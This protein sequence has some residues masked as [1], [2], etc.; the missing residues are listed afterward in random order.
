MGQTG[1]G[2]GAAWG[3]DPGTLTPNPPATMLK[4]LIPAAAL[5]LAAAPLLA[6]A[7]AADETRLLRFPATNGKQIV[8][9]YA[10]QLYTV[11]VDGG[12]ARRLT[13]TPGYAVFPR[14][15]ADGSQ[16]AFTA[17]YD[18][19]TEVY[20]MP[21]EGGTPKRL[22]YTATL[23]RDDVSDRMGPNNLVMAWKNTSNEI[24]FR[25]RMTSF[26]SFV[27]QLYTVGTDG[28]VPKQVPVP[29]GGFLSYSPDDTKMA[30]NQVFREFRTW[31]DYRGGMADDIWIFDFKT[32]AVE[33]ITNDAAQD[34][35]PM[36]GPDNR[37]YFL[38]DREAGGAKRMNLYSYDLATKATAQLTHF[39]DFDIK[40]PSLGGGVV[41]F[42]E[43]GYIWAYDIRKGSAQRVPIAVRDDFVTSRPERINVAKYVESVNIAPDGKRVVV[44]ARG[45]T[46]TVPAK[47]GATRNLTRKEGIHE[48][49][50]VWSPDGRWIAYISD[51][52]GENEIYVRPQD[53]SAE[54]TQLTTGAD[55]YYYFPVWSPDG[56]KLL[57]GD[58]LQRLRFVTVETKAVTLVDTATAFEVTQY[59]WS[60][61]SQWITWA[62]PEDESLSKVWLYSLAGSRKFEVTDG[63]YEAS[64]PAFS[65]DG[66]FLLLASGR[67]FNRTLSEVEFDH[68]YKDLER[69]YL[70]ALSKD[71]DSPF[72]PKSDE[73]EIAPA[74]KPDDKPAD[75]KA[76]DGKDAK[77]DAAP[78]PVVVKVDEDGIKD[79]LVGLPIKA[80][81]YESIHSVGDKVYYLRADEGGDGEEDAGPPPKTLAMYD[82]KERKETELG[83][84]FGYDLSAD[85]KKMLLSVGKDF[86]VIDTPTSKIEVKDR[87]SFAG[88]SMRVDRHAEW[89]QIYDECWRQMRDFFF[90]PTMNGVDW[91]AMRAKYA[92]LVPY[93]QTRYDLTYLLG[94]L[95]GE[96]HSG[97]TYVGGGDRPMAPR[98]TMGLLGAKLSRDPASRDYRIDKI[99]RG[100]NWQSAGRSPLTEIGVNV[101]EG[102]YI[103]AVDGKSVKDM[104][105]IYS[106][107]VGKADVQ[108]VL[109][110][111]SK[112]TD[113]GA[114]NV[115]VL[116]I[117][118]EAPLYYMTWVR[119]NIDYV[120]EKTG[121]KVGYI[122]IPDMGP[123]GLAEFAKHFYPQ[124]TKKA[125]ILDDRGNG[126]GNVSPMIIE[127]LARE[128]LMVEKARNATPRPNPG[129]MQL[130]PKV[131]LM[132][133]F[134][135]SDG[136]IFPYRFKTDGLGKLIGKRS[137]GGVVGIRGSLPIV[138]GGFL[139]KPEFAPY[140]KDGKSWPIE[141]HGVD[142]DIVVS[143]DP[144][145]EFAGVDQQLDRAIEEILQEIKT[146]GQSLPPPPPYPDR[147]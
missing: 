141:G 138:D 49:D 16:L 69:V 30:Y 31:K 81:N 91:A 127:R 96:I 102:D 105:N 92:A 29:R 131:V 59:N 122:H 109:R 62:R 146:N 23:S 47:D 4:L 8:F 118:D 145:K 60:P 38:S 100:E 112:P 25:S 98:V 7:P 144:S 37:I 42:E 50:A 136:D 124:L 126:G 116:P 17:Q 12:E 44:S 27:G 114:R 93:A 125:L 46:F 20:V 132:D 54:P 34:I 22:T 70:I 64:A 18:G 80:S 2:I 14:F 58:R 90:S 117:G 3:H 48:R 84:T 133:E 128:L 82:L 13:N 10:D 137:W 39:T 76:A 43:A 41:V 55:T 129:D 57:W 95:I 134:S 1:I 21:A 135:A 67:D 74:P 104:A 140:A 65:D 87:L 40:F 53:A 147:S 120:T 33:D 103:L 28:D 61:D 94:E 123:E 68:V 51:D 115:T 32:G 83:K 75:A 99:L 77:K 56:K 19:N 97:H 5:A 35:I 107:L 106:A 79:R 121:G 78:K 101:R 88:L 142:P 63:W 71:T 15:S 9:S 73:V 66:K 85:G 113:E 45:A 111:N 6:Q 110:V 130:G 143:N 139:N 89:A 86:A 119:H 36:W 52:T 26:N 108:V 72:K 24:A 11:G